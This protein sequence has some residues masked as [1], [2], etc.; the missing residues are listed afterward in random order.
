[1]CS[2]ATHTP[3]GNLVL[4]TSC[5]SSKRHFI[6]MI[7]WALVNVYQ[8]A[9]WKNRNKN[10]QKPWVL[11]FPNFHGVNTPTMANF[12]LPPQS[13]WPRSWEEMHT[14][15]SHKPAQDGF[16]PPVCE[17]VYIWVHMYMFLYIYLENVICGYTFTQIEAYH[18]YLGI[19]DMHAISLYVLHSLLCFK[20]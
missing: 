2:F 3:F 13:H 5:V 8:P 19:D 11:A 15:G 12:K 1:M 10:T 9:L 7:Q 20:C 4:S 17:Y 18:T 16:S 14:I 6:F